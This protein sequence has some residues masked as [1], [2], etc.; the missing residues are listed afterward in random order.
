MI[1]LA[2]RKFNRLRV[3][4]FAGRKF[5]S[6]YWRCRCQCGVVKAIR[7]HELLYGPTIGCGNATTGCRRVKGEPLITAKDGFGMWR[8]PQQQAKQMLF[9]AESTGLG[10]G[11]FLHHV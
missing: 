8:I 4:G 6:R 3:L 9:A 1:D 7:E 2:G 10:V 5:G 11:S